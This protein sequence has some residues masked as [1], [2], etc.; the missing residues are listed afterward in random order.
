MSKAAEKYAAET[1]EEMMQVM[2]SRSKSAPR[3]GKAS[4][5]DDERDSIDDMIETLSAGNGASSPAPADVRS[6]RFEGSARSMLWKKKSESAKAASRV[7]ATMPVDRQLVTHYH[8]G[9]RANNNTTVSMRILGFRIFG[10]CLCCCCCCVDMK[11]DK[12][13][14]IKAC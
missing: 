4:P 13:N 5:Y 9:V 14:D 11:S 8:L 6:V 3:S 12:A 7:E 2:A 1:V 10:C